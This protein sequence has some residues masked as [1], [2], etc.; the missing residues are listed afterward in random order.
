M[1]LGGGTFTAQD[2]VLPGA[3]IN[4]VSAAQASTMLSD[5]GIV[6]MPLQLDWGPDGEVFSVTAD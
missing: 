3:Y 2:K 6:A 4:F 5:R 1:A